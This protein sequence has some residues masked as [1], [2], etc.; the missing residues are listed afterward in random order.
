MVTLRLATPDD[1][2]LIADIARI[3][4]SESAYGYTYS[5]ANTRWIVNAYLTDP[6][7]AVMIAEIDE[8]TAG[9]WIGCVV[10]EW[11]NEPL[12]Y[13]NK[14]YVLP[15]ARG[16][17]VSDA[18][19]ASFVKWADDN[20]CL[21]SFAT[22]TANVGGGRKFQELCQRHGFVSAGDTMMRRNQ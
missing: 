15:W 2:D 22:A 14:F 12:C 7:H 4:I 19:M 3:F 20:D 9:I 18:L 17:G 13:L 1:A 6:Y 5:E 10:H 11:T 16:K 21:D 8:H